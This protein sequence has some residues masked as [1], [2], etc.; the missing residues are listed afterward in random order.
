MK[1]IMENLIHRLQ[2]KGWTKKEISRVVSIIKEEHKKKELSTRYIDKVY[3]ALLLVILAAN[4]ALSIAL[5]PILMFLSG[6]ILY[7]IIILV[8][9]I[10]GLL[11]ELIIRSI[12]HLEEH[13]HFVLALLIPVIA[14]ANSYAMTKYANNLMTS[15]GIQNTHDL[16][17]VAFVYSISFV[18]PYFIFRFVLEIEYYSKG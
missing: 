15:V 3:W 5:V 13:H 8:G 7:A 17:A 10:F 9:T 11:F 1:Q 14:L 6:F 16:F 4:F 18:L 12:E 2:K